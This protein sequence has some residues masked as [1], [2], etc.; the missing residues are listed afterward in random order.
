MRER[1]HQSTG[2]AKFSFQ[3]YKF[4][5]MDFQ[6]TCATIQNRGLY[7][8]AFFHF[9][10]S[11]LNCNSIAKADDYKI[12][13]IEHL[14]CFCSRCLNISKMSIRRQSACQQIV[15]FFLLFGKHVR[16]ILRQW[17]GRSLFRLPDN[18]IECI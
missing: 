5:L 7:L 6:R 2:A 15:A 16:F 11:L 10:N 17:C 14:A 12:I 13:L 8:R 9:D 1:W 18:E 4:V 3:L